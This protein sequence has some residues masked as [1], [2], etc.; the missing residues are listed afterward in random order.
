MLSESPIRLLLSGSLSFGPGKA[1]LLERI[2]QSGSLQAAAAAMD[3]S[4]MKAWKMVK[5]LNQRF[6]EP[7]VVMHRGG[8]TQGGA[9]LTEL[10]G[11]ILALY[12]EAVKA[13]ETATFPVLDQMRKKLAA[14]ESNSSA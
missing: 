14:D 10:G 2:K 12:H 6:S 5:G 13:A 4:Y 1:E 9:D 3:M 8:N 11:E 7:L